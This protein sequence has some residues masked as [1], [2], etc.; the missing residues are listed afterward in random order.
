MLA[1]LGMKNPCSVDIS[2]TDVQQTFTPISRSVTKLK[3]KFLWAIQE[4]ADS[5]THMQ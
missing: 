3:L 1:S 2:Q 4:D 5:L